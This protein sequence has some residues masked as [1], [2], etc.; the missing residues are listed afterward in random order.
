MWLRGTGQN[1]E[2]DWLQAESEVLS[3]SVKVLLWT[4]VNGVEYGHI[5]TPCRVADIVYDN[6]NP[7]V[8]DSNKKTIILLREPRLSSSEHV[9]GKYN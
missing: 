7:T 8:V 3:L 2:Q 4:S 1:A 5:E 9:Y 6:G